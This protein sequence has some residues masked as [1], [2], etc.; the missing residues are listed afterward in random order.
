MHLLVN[1]LCEY[2]NA[3]CNDKNLLLCFICN[4]T[5]F[6]SQLIARA[7]VDCDEHPVPYRT[8]FVLPISVHYA[9]NSRNVNVVNSR[10]IQFSECTSVM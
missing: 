5:V 1:E 4:V 3:R 8:R 10:G 7:V 9:V 6:V 2:Q